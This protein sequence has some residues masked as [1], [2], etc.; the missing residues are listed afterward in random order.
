M[1]ELGSGWYAV[2]ANAVDANTT[3]PL[4]LH[5]TATGCDPRDDTFVVTQYNPTN[6]SPVSPPTT[7]FGTTTAL[8]IITRALTTIGVKAQGED[9]SGA[10]AQDGFRRLNQMIDGWGTETLTMQVTTRTEFALVANQQEYTVGLGGDWDIVRPLFIT[11]CGLILNTVTPPVEIPMAV[12][13]DDAY[14]AIQVK[15]LTNPLPTLL[16]YNP[17]FPFG[18]AFLWPNPTNAMNTI[19]LYTR[20]AMVGFASLTT[21]YAFPPGYEAMLEYQLAVRLCAPYTRPLDP[22][23]K[24]LADEAIGKVKRANIKL[25]DAA[26]DLGLTSTGRRGYYNIYTDQG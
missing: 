4:L 20:T 8:D 24:Q 14:E 22:L 23:V 15:T 2:A 10:E 7:G 17:T 5:A 19:A 1:T 21:Q 18:T 16:Y 11:G 13:T 9:L 26:L 25:T 12:I 6:V 3:G